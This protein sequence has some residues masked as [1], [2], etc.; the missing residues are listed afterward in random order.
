L[1]TGKSG[2]P[3]TTV[4]P[5]VEPTRTPHWKAQYGQWVAVDVVGD[6]KVAT[7]LLYWFALSVYRIGGPVQAVNQIVQKMQSK[8]EF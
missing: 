3:T 1:L 5:S 6:A 4:A 7:G 8:R 2:S